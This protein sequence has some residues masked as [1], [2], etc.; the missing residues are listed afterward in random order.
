MPSS[1]LSRRGL[2]AGLLAMP[3]AARAQLPDRPVRML[4]GFPAGTAP[5]VVARLLAD[6][7]KESLPSGVVVD[8]RAGAG[9]QIAAQEV[10]RAAPDGTT[11]LFAE[12]GQLAMAPSTYARLPYN[13]ARDFV[14]VAQ[15]VTSD[16]AFVIPAAVP[17]SDMESYIA[18]ARGRQIF[19]GTFGAGSPNH[20]GAM[21]LAGQNGLNV[22]AVHFRATGEGI[23]ALLNGNLQGMFGSVALLAP[24][25][26]A[27]RVK[28]LGTTGVTRSP[29][30]PQIATF[31][32]QG[33]PGLVFEAWFGVVAPTGVPEP[34][35]VALEAAVLRA[36]SKPEVL[37]RLREASFKPVP[38]GRVAFGNLIRDDTARW[39]EI[40]RQTGFRAIE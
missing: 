21:M 39:A 2:V 9:G 5:D 15:V 10:A 32:E 33:R 24:H 40:V 20:F 7:M 18:W 27:G 36:L 37:A 34:A 30:L 1:W 31:G 11:L 25:I 38:N 6:A 23:T 26:Q 13:P 22:E 19:M 16:F 3:M 12:V 35:M 14:P 4:V 17:A 8:N 28:A 29:M